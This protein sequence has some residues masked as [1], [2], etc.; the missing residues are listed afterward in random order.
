MRDLLINE[1]ITADTVLLPNDRGVLAYTP[2]KEAL[3]QARQQNKDL[4]VENHSEP[5]VCQIVELIQPLRWEQ[6]AEI[7]DPPEFDEALWFLDEECTGKHYVLG[8]A[9]TFRGRIQAWCPTKEKSFFI[10]SSEISECSRE[11]K[12]FIRG[13]LAGQEPA[14]PVDDQGHLLPPEDED[15]CAWR[16]ATAQFRD[17]GLWVDRIRFCDRCGVRLLPSTPTEACHQCTNLESTD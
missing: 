3:A 11:T 12:Y 14:P 5:P 2:L 17:T 13:F 7:P 4:V 16:H 6:H 1:Q 10:S 8:N 9:H 15:F